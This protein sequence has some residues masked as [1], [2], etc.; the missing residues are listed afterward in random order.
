LAKQVRK[1]PAAHEF[2]AIPRGPFDLQTQAEHFGGF[3]RLDEAVVMPF[4][5]EG[6]RGSAAV[7]LRQEDK[8]VAGQVHGASAADAARAWQQALAT[9]SLDVDGRGFV[10]VGRRDPVIA[11]LQAEYH[12]VRPVLFYSPYEAACSFLIGHRITILQTRRLRAKMA[13][14]AGAAVSVDGQTFHAFPDPHALLRLEE[15]PGVAGVKIER[16]HAAA[17]AAL[18]GLLIRD[19]LRALPESEAIQKLKALPGIGEFFAQA[20]L[21]RG[22][23]LVDAVTNDD[24]TPRAVE[25]LY[26][27]KERPDYQSLLK[28]AESWRP[29][30]MWAIVLLNVWVRSQPPEVVG[31]RQIRNRRK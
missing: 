20:I 10:E 15:F 29:F 26:K 19:N 11:R 22:A 5:V 18:D 14:V 1:A 16:L 2:E 12:H 9:L 8:R 6:W 21:M 4:P 17:R 7:V 13:E 31:R 28:R 24:L 25:L 3:P 23:G 27:L 30:R